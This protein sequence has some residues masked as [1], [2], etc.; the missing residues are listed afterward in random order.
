MA[1]VVYMGTP[2]FAVP[3]LE[4]LV[5]HHEVVKN[6]DNV[7]GADTWLRLSELQ[8]RAVDTPGGTKVGQIGDVVLDEEARVTG[9][10]LSKVYVAGTIAEDPYIPRSAMLDTGGADGVM[11][12][13]LPK[14]ERP[15][16]VTKS[17]TET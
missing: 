12:I 8:G 15:E 7:D 17:E 3:V 4:A 16:A 13:D 6:E 14:A 1:R 11:S 5:K 10:R 9:F 2:Q